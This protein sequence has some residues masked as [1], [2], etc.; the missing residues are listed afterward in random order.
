MVEKTIRLHPSLKTLAEELRPVIENV[1]ARLNAKASPG[2]ETSDIISV[3]P[4]HSDKLKDA[5]GHIATEVKAIGAACKDNAEPAVFIRL[6]GRLEACLDRFIEGYEEA[7][8]MK[9][10]TE[11]VHGRDLL[12]ATYRH[13]LIEVLGFM[14][15]MVEVCTNPKTALEKQ[16]SSGDSQTVVLHLELTGAPQVDELEEWIEKRAGTDS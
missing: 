1:R 9:L 4:R 12:V 16:E 3:L 14:C 6:V 15:Q 8:D 5:V 7:R 2:Q 13:T 11:D 10:P